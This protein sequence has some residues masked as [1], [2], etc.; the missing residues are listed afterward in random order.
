MPAEEA[1]SKGKE[2]L[3][4]IE[5]AQCAID[6]IV[7]LN[8]ALAQANGPVVMV[9]NEIGL[10]VIPLGRGVRHFVD[11]LGK[12]NQAVAARCERVTLMAAGCALSLKGGA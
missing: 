8:A 9:S 2:A 4:G 11:E 3:A 1:F 10:G 12:L 5:S 7:G 6:L